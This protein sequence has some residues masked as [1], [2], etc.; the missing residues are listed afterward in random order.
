MYLALLASP[1]LSVAQTVTTNPKVEESSVEDVRIV[2]VE[3]TSQHTAIYLRY[4]SS[5]KG[6]PIPGNIPPQFRDYFRAQPSS[7]E[8]WLDPNTRLYKPGD[9][10]TKFRFLRAEGIPTNPERKQVADGE[11][12]EFVAYFEKVTPGI[13]IIDFYEGKSTG[14]TR[15]WNFYGIHI[16]N[17]DA[18]KQ[19]RQEPK[20]EAPVAKDDQT[21]GVAPA[22]I[23]G[24]SM[25]TGQ[26]FHA[27]TGAAIAAEIRYVEEGDTIVVSTSSG[28][29]RIGLTSGRSYTFIASSK[30][31]GSETWV[32]DPTIDTVSNGLIQHDFKLSPLAEGTTFTLE[33][34]YFETSSFTLLAESFEELDKFV[35]ILKENPS[36]TIRVEGHTDNVGNFDKNVELSKQR[37]EAVKNYLVE[38]GI[39]AER[40]EAKG[41]GPT[42]PVAKGGTEEQ[43]QKNR[44]VEIVIVRS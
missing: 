3:I 32:F 20:Q 7:P 17:P 36:I 19:P 33:N 39:G 16:N 27:S 8:I 4:A 35:R 2:R 5:G 24:I 13:E 26:V 21:I 43:K 34:I 12:V 9:V 37:A 41:Y 38:K 25:L 18:K 31:F 6:N 15:A 11:V 29:Y 22:R 10:N 44:R 40:V 1:L 14:Q 23:A 30:G 28:R 42:K